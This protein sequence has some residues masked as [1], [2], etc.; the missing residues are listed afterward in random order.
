MQVKYSVLIFMIQRLLWPLTSLG[1]MLD[2]YQRSKA[3]FERILE[4]INTNYNIESGNKN[5]NISDQSITLKTF[6]EKKQIRSVG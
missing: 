4:L 1:T 2:L 6:G 3:S 5:F